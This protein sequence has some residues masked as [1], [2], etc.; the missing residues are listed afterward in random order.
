MGVYFYNYSHIYKL[1]FG[2]SWKRS[3][4]EEIWH[5]IGSF[6]SQTKLLGYKFR[7]PRC[8]S[9]FECTRFRFQVT[10]NI[11]RILFWIQI[12]ILLGTANV[13]SQDRNAGYICLSKYRKYL[14]FLKVPLLSTRVTGTYDRVSIRSN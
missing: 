4:N 13:G 11:I 6:H 7:L 10:G 14:G 3:L 2:I 1:Y 9:F 12:L 8:I 5:K